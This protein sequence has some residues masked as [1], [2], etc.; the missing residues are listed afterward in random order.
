MLDA[1]IKK[2]E[3]QQKLN[4]NTPAFTVGEHLKDI[5]K[6]CSSQ[7]CEIVLKDLE[8]EKMSI[9]EC[10]KRIAKY[11]SVHRN[12]NTSFCPPNVAEEIICKFYGISTESKPVE[13]NSTFVDLSDFI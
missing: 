8:V 6:K 1:V 3:E 10:E 7:C 4:V 9:S 5:L 11:A 2:I 12:G 13:S